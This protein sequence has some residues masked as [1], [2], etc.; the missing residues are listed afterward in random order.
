[1]TYGQGNL[2]AANSTVSI[3]ASKSRII[4]SC[5]MRYVTENVYT[6]A[7]S[8][9]TTVRPSY[10]PDQRKDAAGTPF[11]VEDAIAPSGESLKLV[12]FVLRMNT[13]MGYLSMSF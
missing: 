8:T 11:T 2:G 5:G 9:T 13:S 4:S 6:H 1:M 3:I 12:K 7:S 10:N